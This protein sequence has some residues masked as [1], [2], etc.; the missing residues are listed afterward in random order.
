MEY[1]SDSDVSEGTR[2]LVRQGLASVKRKR[3][4][5][6]L[7]S[8]RLPESFSVSNTDTSQIRHPLCQDGLIGVASTH[9]LNSTEREIVN[10]QNYNTMMGCS[11]T[12]LIGQRVVA[13]ICRSLK[14]DDVI[15]CFFLILSVMT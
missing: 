6:A 5:V 7:Q 2:D 8:E 9:G 10:E 4:V 14:S 1:T 3:V 12:G 15:L 11:A 13:Y